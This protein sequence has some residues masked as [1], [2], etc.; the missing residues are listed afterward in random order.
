MKHKAPKVEFEKRGF[1]LSIKSL[2]LK[3]TRPRYL[4]RLMALGPE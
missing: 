3:G 1:F 4:K 2:S